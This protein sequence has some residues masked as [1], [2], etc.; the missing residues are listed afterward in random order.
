M[1]CEHIWSSAKKESLYEEI[2][3][4]KKKVCQR[5]LAREAR[6]ALSR[7]TMVNEAKQFSE[8]L[9]ADAWLPGFFSMKS[10]QALWMAWKSL[11]ALSKT[12]SLAWVVTAFVT[13]RIPRALGNCPPISPLISSV[14][15][16]EFNFEFAFPAN[17]QN[18]KF[19]KDKTVCVGRHPIHSSPW[20]K[21]ECLDVTHC[22]SVLTLP[23]TCRGQFG[24]TFKSHANFLSWEEWGRKREWFVCSKVEKKHLTK[25]YRGT[26]HTQ[27]V[28]KSRNRPGL[29]QIHTQKQRLSPSCQS[30]SM[31]HHTFHLVCMYLTRFPST[32]LG[33]RQKR[34]PWIESDSAGFLQSET[35][36]AMSVSEGVD[37]RETRIVETK[38]YSPHSTCRSGEP[39]GLGVQ[40]SCQTPWP[41]QGWEQLRTLLDPCP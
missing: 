11:G 4:C 14:S 38:K 19:D 1:C 15:A 17:L 13:V 5:L 36:W 39:Q 30:W 23:F 10:S 16:T 37:V 18:V 9:C 12:A 27:I 3:N 29:S 21:T 31:C 32:V 28:S 34:Q 40:T 20:S 7:K 2:R 24:A 33:W 35:N 41:H 25:K 26:T 8:S 22:P 6:R